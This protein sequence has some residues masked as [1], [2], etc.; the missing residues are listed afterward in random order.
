MGSSPLPSSHPAA[1]H[2]SCRV[3]CPSRLGFKGKWVFWKHPEPEAGRF[4][5]SHR[6]T[7]SHIPQLFSTP[8]NAPR[9]SPAPVAPASLQ[10]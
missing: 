1:S 5:P 4:C 9:A 10:I 6:E 3:L 2:P 8:T 7:E